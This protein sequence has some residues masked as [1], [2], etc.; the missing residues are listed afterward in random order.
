MV[1][2]VSLPVHRRRSLDDVVW[3]RGS[4]DG[5]RA[6][7]QALRA[8]AHDKVA[9][10]RALVGDRF[11]D[12]LR[13]TDAI[14]L[15]RD[16]V[17]G[18]ADMLQALRVQFRQAAKIQARIDDDARDAVRRRQEQADADRQAKID[19]V[20]VVMTPERVWA[21]LDAH[22]LRGAVS[23]HSNGKVIG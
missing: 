23:A 16:E 9:E 19:R 20:A 14:A 12:L 17:A 6:A 5:A 8:H 22:D 11:R 10:L 15:M 18:A 2:A 21:A 1:S 3:T 7:E 13:T 4:V